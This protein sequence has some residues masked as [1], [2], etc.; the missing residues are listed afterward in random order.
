SL[1]RA[2]GCGDLLSD[3]K[4]DASWKVNQGIDLQIASIRKCIDV[5]GDV[6]QCSYY[7]GPIGYATGG[8]PA[9]DARASGSTTGAPVP[10]SA[11]SD[12]A[13][14]YSETNT[15]V[16]GVDEADIIKNDGKNLYV[17][18]GNAFKVINAWPAN[19]LREISSTD[20]E[21]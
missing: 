6:Q 15:Q 16:K 7:G 11:P 21:G 9:S 8:A 12:S 13:S 1:H 3:L 2:Q 18:H 19:D 4:A 5:L 17:L 10:S 20:V 14:S